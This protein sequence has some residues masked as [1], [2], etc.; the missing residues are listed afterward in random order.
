MIDDLPC[1][2]CQH[3]RDLEAAGFLW[4]LL[5]VVWAL[6]PVVGYGITTFV[7]YSL[8]HASFSL[9]STRIC[10]EANHLSEASGRPRSPDQNIRKVYQVHSASNRLVVQR[11]LRPVSAAKTQLTVHQQK[12]FEGV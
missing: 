10:F 3:L 5:A 8:R 11:S 1:F 12:S 6:Y 7:R 9:I 4:H 2:V